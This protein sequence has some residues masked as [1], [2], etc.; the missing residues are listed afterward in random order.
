VNKTMLLVEDDPTDELLTLRAF[1][2]HALAT[3]VVIARD[4]SEALDFMFCT[5]IHAG[6]DVTAQ[7]SLVLLD[8]KLPRIS[9]LEVLARI[10]ADERTRAV[11][12]VILTASR[13][14]QDVDRSYQLG[15]PTW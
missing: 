4:G 14:E 6:R 10:R 8:L 5:G 9:G 12:V 3:D 7:P 2:K 15:V 1:K 13:E 11:P